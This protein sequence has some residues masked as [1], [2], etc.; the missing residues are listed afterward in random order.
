MAVT[1]RLLIYISMLKNKDGMSLFQ[2]RRKMGYLG[3]YSAAQAVIKIF[4]DYVKPDNSQLAY[5]LTYK[6]SHDHL[7]LWFGSIRIRGR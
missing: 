7:E 3:F 5:L 1:N 2:T 4:D 6:L